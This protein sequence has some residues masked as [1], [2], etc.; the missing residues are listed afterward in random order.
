MPPPNVTLAGRNLTRVAWNRAAKLSRDL[1][2]RARRAGKHAREGGKAA[3]AR[4][5]ATAAAGRDAGLTA[6][7]GTVRASRYWARVHERTLPQLGRE[8]SVRRELWTAAR[9]SGPIIAGPWLG[10][11]GYEVLYWVP[12]LRWF[13][14]HY[15]VHPSR[16]VAVSRG[17]VHG[18]Y[19]GVAD[20]YVELLD[21]YTPDEFAARNAA[22]QTDGEQKQHGRGAFDAAIVDR[23]RAMPGLGGAAV[24]HSSAMFRLLRQFWLGNESLE[25]V[26]DHM[27]FAPVTTAPGLTLPPLPSRFVAMKFYTGRALPDTPANRQ[28]LRGLVEQAASTHP[29]V[30]LNTGLALDEHEDFLFRDVP[31]VTTVSHALTAANNLA[32]QTE[33]IRRA[34]RFVGTCGSLAWLAPM[35]GTETLAVY[36]DDFLLTP[37]LYAA[38]QAYRSIG[39]ARFTPLDIHALVGLGSRRPESRAESRA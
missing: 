17:G 13:A 6:Y 26:L 34:D 14:D 39:A 5:R 37:H 38:R 31:G 36:D 32:V 20:H 28:A 8:L 10:E 24:C 21:L 3:K 27:R 18:W 4:V 30:M 23:V 16:I 33:V 11:V 12:F 15:R 9:G 1:L 35:L 22:R 19:A 25:Y 29:I 7:T 2:H